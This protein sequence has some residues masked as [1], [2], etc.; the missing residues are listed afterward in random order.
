MSTQTLSPWND[1]VKLR[2]DVESGALTELVLAI[3]Q[4]YSR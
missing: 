4:K 1:L 3:D 2:P